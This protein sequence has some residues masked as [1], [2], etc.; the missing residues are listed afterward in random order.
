MTQE[1]F[2]SSNGSQIGPVDMAEL[3]RLASGGELK[4]DDLV[5]RD[6]LDNWVPASTVPDV[7]AATVSAEPIPAVRGCRGRRH[8][9]ARRCST[10][11]EPAAR[12]AQSRRPSSSPWR[13][14][15]RSAPRHRLA[16]R[17][18]FAGAAYQIPELASVFTGREPPANSLSYRSNRDDAKLARILTRAQRLAAVAG[19][20]AGLVVLVA[21]NLPIVRSLAW[22]PSTGGTSPTLPRGHRVRILPLPGFERGGGDVRRARA[23][24]RRTRRDDARARRRSVCLRRFGKCVGGYAAGTGR[25]PADARRRRFVRDVG[26]SA[27]G[28]H[29]L[30]GRVS[31]HVV[32]VLLLIGLVSFAWAIV[33]TTIA[34]KRSRA[35]CRRHGRSTPEPWELVELMMNV[36]MVVWFVSATVAGIFAMLPKATAGRCYAI[37]SFCIGYF[38]TAFL[39]ML[40]VYL[41]LQRSGLPIPAGGPIDDRPHP[42]DSG[43]LPGARRPGDSPSADRTPFRNCPLGDV[44]PAVY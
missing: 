21:V 37:R 29:D 8:R 7:F 13:S 4:P 10:T 6:G 41:S 25:L 43:G 2:Y 36:L 40:A 24:H 42:C 32:G 15:E 18:E 9:R 35:P 17:G 31:Q 20:T 34:F 26:V 44:V 12:S 5:W 27:G 11:R 30:G 23:V 1:W 3:S 14:M 22:F 28:P 33:D 19:I 39:M 16:R 38:L